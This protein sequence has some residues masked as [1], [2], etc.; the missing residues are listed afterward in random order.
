MTR[1]RPD[2]PNEKMTEQERRKP[3]DFD[4]DNYE[5]QADREVDE[6]LDD[7]LDIGDEDNEC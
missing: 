5:T 3:E 6:E 7:L 4:D 1:P 2:D